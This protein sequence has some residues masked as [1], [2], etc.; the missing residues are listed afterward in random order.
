MGNVGG[1]E[2]TSIIIEST[3][4][5][6][7]NV[8]TNIENTLVSKLPE[9]SSSTSSSTSSSLT[10]NSS[11]ENFDFFTLKLQEIFQKKI[12]KL[13][14]NDPVKRRMSKSSVETLVLDINHEILR[15]LNPKGDTYKKYYSKMCKIK[16]MIDS[17]YNQHS[18]FYYRIL[19]GHLTPEI[20]A[21]MTEEELKLENAIE[22]ESITLEDE[23]NDLNDNIN[24]KND[25][26]M[27][28]ED[29]VPLKI[30]SKS[31]VNT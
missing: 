3:T 16:N 20:L 12:D 28:D 23:P 25:E 22:N 6:K 14:N 29:D 31:F 13:K 27:S 24:N 21:K 7:P 8:M 11:N 9:I 4:K 19:S 1:D 30:L 26:I 2:E 10:L 5:I 18:R 17:E 15:A